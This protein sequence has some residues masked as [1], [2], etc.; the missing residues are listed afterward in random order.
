MGI[1]LDGLVSGL[2]TTELIKSLMDVNAI[3]RNLLKSKMTDKGVIISNLQ[4]LNSSLQDIATKAKAALAPGAMARF[5]TSSSASGVS[6]SATKDADPVTAEIVVDRVAQRHSVVTAAYAAWP[7]EPPVLTLQNSAGERVE[8]TATSSSPQDVAKAITAAGFGITARAVSAGTDAEGAPLY[9]LQLSAAETGAT[10]TFR[11]DRGDVASVDAGTSTD[12][13]TEPGAATIT[14]GADAQIRLW[15]GT[16][17]E[18]VVTSSTGSFAD[19]FTGVNVTVT[20]KPADPVTIG[21]TRDASA[22]AKASGDLISQ[23]AS[24]LTRIDN[25]STATVPSGAGETTTLGVFTG[26]STVRALRRALADAVQYPVDD[27]SP[28]SIGIS[29]DR[30]GV[31]S[32]DQAKY[33]AALA[34]DPERVA[35]VFAGVVERVQD[36]AE[37][38]SDKHDGLLTARII[39]Q[40]GEVDAI[41]E[42]IGRW[43]VRLAQRKA[44]LE[45]TYAQLE[46]Q[47]S[48]MQSQSSYLSSQLAALTPK[49]NGSGS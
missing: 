13:A 6:V 17:A 44:T 46:V 38:Y 29:V 26:D 47:L 30:H 23:L 21:V 48:R 1:A 34:E 11:V 9:R 14:T 22:Q 24:L 45:R 5:A 15:A 37:T 25:G 40:Q 16:A 42:Q 41:G 35:Q 27:V 10:G 7:D 33:T 32:F 31:L 12:L 36:V 20:A 8:V 49:Q 2:N 18:Q 3:P 19:L 39:G 4:S 28:S 43:D